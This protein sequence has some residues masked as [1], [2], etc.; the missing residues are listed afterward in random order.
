MR[1]GF[2]KCGSRM[3]RGK[4]WVAPLSYH[5][6]M[7]MSETQVHRP[8]SVRRAC[9]HIKSTHLQASRRAG[10]SCRR[11]PFRNQWMAT[12]ISS[13]SVLPLLPGAAVSLRSVLLR[14]IPVRGVAPSRR[15]EH[16]LLAAREARGRRQ[17]RGKDDDDDLWRSC[18]VMALGF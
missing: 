1:S 16:R 5:T 11:R 8:M 12:V 18:V 2:A 14:A 7:R 6:G 15:T 13:S 10:L 4:T 9:E 17:R 3:K